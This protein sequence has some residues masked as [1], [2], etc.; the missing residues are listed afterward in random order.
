MRRLFWF[1]MGFA[2]SCALLVLLLWDHG[3][4][5][6][7]ILL[8]LCLP[9]AALSRRAK[10]ARFPFAVLLGMALGSGLLLF[11][12]KIYYAPLLRLD[13]QT[14]PVTLTAQADSV[15]G[16][17]SEMVRAEMK[18]GSRRYTVRA[19]LGAGQTARA[20]NVLR[21]DFKLQATLPGGSKEN[22]VH[23]GRGILALASPKGE[24]SV[25]TGQ[26]GSARYLPQRLGAAAR[27]AVETCFPEDTAAFAKS[28]LLGDTADLSYASETALRISGIRHI[29]AVSGLHVAILFGFLWVLC[30]RRPL[31]AC[32]IGIPLLALFAAMVGSTPSV[33]RACLM[34]A[35]LVL[36]RLTRRSYDAL[37]AWAFAV[38]WL[39]TGNP[40]VIAAAGFQLSVLCV[41]GILLFQRPFSERLS[42]LLRKLPKGNVLADSLAVSL[43]AT[44]LSL[45]VSVFY[46]ATASLIAPVTNFLILWLLPFLFGGILAVCIL[47]PLIPALGAAL[48]WLTAWPI[49]L[50]LFIAGSL[51][52][53]PM[54]AVY[55]CNP[56]VVPWL[57]FIY[58][59]W[60]LW[61]VTKR[62]K[63]FS[64]F[65][66]GLVSLV[67]V[68]ALWGYGPRVDDCR[69]TVLDVGQGQ[70]LLLQSGGQ[71][72][73][74]DCGGNSDTV[75]A[76]RAWQMLRSQNFYDLDLLL[77]THFD[78]DH[79]GGAENFLTQIPAEE[80][81]LPG[82][83]P[84]LPTGQVVTEDCDIPFGVGV[85][86]LFPYTGGNKEQENSMA[87]LFE[88]ENCGI[89]VTG[90]L[91]IAGERRLVKTHSVA[92]DI[93]IV[94]HHGS[95]NAT[96]RELLD[97]VQPELALISVGENHY[98]H[99]T[100][101]VLD[102][103][104][105]A[106]CT[107]RR[108][109]NEGTIIIRR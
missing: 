48:G 108:T 42:R 107:V 5:C 7:A 39:L 102:R 100:Q 29:V 63:G 87:I 12:Q 62:R 97:A 71:S 78:R 73:L 68:T 45:P 109:D 20:G 95:K 31:P 41:L 75:S 28:L 65:C 40:L 21:G 70:S 24:I 27:E 4:V 32:L 8:F 59:L 96:C 9:L 85:L 11:L 86:H 94:G 16:Q 14:L 74:I 88:T 61:V 81:I 38:L 26:E 6:F 34:A 57:V 46:F 58:G 103:L 79:F 49:R 2:L 105:E 1:S 47:G 53:L 101:E 84:L 44:V 54:A 66:A 36:S 72:A 64:F 43:S 56:Y 83:S 106:G 23:S 13:G 25:E 92:A 37:T 18:I 19:F 76:D 17:Y 50:V 77:F 104:E 69:L 3:A 15:P 35:L 99:P 67:A 82:A 33:I 30:A 22:S 60:L 51:S 91:D 90:D 10:W 89:L 55:T 52:K 98:G 93:L 80:V